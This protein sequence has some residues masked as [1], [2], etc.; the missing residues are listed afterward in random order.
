M[1]EYIINNAYG[2]L[3]F[4]NGIDYQFKISNLSF[5]KKICL[6]YLFTYD[7]YLKAV[8]KK[9]G[10][11]YKL[12]VYIDESLLMIPTQR[13]RNFDNI[14]INYAAIKKFYQHQGGIE[15]VFSSDIKLIVDIS[16]ESFRRE[17]KYLDIIR[18]EKVKHFHI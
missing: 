10:K 11:I 15:I 12:P 7:S 6:D 4:Q 17:I 18:K 14:W 16:I 5:I 13:N 9:L 3:V 1:I 2:C 8:Q